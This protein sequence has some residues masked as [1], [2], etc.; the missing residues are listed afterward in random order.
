MNYLIDAGRFHDDVHSTIQSI[1]EVTNTFGGKG[2]MIILRECFEVNCFQQEK[3]LI[4]KNKKSRLEYLPAIIGWIRERRKL[5][6]GTAC[7]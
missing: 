3:N 5:H 4:F 7:T 6:S 2:L 1:P